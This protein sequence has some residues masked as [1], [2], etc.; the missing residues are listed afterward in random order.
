MK[1]GTRDARSEK[2]ERV[3]ERE[4]ESGGE[5]KASAIKSCQEQHKTRRG[6]ATRHSS[7]GDACPIG[8]CMLPI[9]KCYAFNI[10]LHNTAEITLRGQS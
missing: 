2:R 7:S 9:G 8:A 1:C 5:C 6:E 3:R 4:R 10:A